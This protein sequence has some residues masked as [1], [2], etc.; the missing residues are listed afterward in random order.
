MPSTSEGD[1]RRDH[2]ETV[3]REKRE[4][5]VSWFQER[6]QTSL[7]L[8]ARTGLTRKARVVDVGGGASRLVDALASLGYED[9]AVVDIAAA[10]LAKARARLGEHGERVRWIQADVLGWVPDTTFDVW[11]DR[12]VFH[13][14][15]REEDR[16]A[17]RATLHRAL[18]RGGHAIVATFATNGPSTC[19]GLP[20]RRY[21]PD[22]L[23]AELGPE[24][25]LVES[26]RE[27]HTTPAG[28]VQAFQFS[29]FV[30]TS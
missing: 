1:S 19:S 30:R 9:V 2:W 8:I 10:A 4:T 16:R 22:T 3:F 13:F 28:K 20:V 29:R 12:A 27:E 14:M 17:Y 25:R 6:P 24:L 15:V 5:E 21:E 18:A 11:H 7:D 26:V 23:E